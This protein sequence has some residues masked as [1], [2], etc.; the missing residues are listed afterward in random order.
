MSQTSFDVTHARAETTELTENER[1][2]L[3][4]DERRHVAL[5]VLASQSTPISLSDFTAK[6]AQREYGVDAPDESTLTRVEISLHH[7]H[8][9]KMDDL[10]VLHY[11]PGSHLIWR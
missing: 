1:H 4:A 9:P 8:L 7:C 6:V 11:D 5:D 3:L 10:G 2:E